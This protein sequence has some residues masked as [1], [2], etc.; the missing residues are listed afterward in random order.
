MTEI[1]M[2]EIE[3]SEDTQKDRYLT[4]YM[5]D[6]SYAIEIQ[7]VIEIIGLQIITEIPELP[8]YIKGIINLRGRIIPVMDMRIR[9]KKPIVPYSERTCVIIVEIEGSS[10]GFIV[11]GVSEVITISE[12]DSVEQPQIGKSQGNK[13]IKKIGKVGNDVKLIIDC[14]K[15][16]SMD[17]LQDLNEMI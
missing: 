6:E 11:D 17:E 13:Y 8:D 3:A 9:F 7:Y 12:Q 1:S 5:G 16:V 10:I 15:L 2:E 4:F 14:D